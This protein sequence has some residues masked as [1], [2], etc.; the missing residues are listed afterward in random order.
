MQKHVETMRKKK[1]QRGRER[2]C[3]RERERGREKRRKKHHSHFD[4]LI[5]V[6]YIYIYTQIYVIHMYVKDEIVFYLIASFTSQWMDKMS[7]DT[8][9]ADLSTLT[10]RTWIVYFLFAH[11]KSRSFPWSAFTNTGV[12]RVHR[13]SG[14]TTNI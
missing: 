6:W 3:V 5:Y 10:K 13:K 4:E 7:F 8:P 9:S 2:V 14:F 12:H 11:K 1:K